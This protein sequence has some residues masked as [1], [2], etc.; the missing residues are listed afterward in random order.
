MLRRGILMGLVLAVTVGAAAGGARAANGADA[1]KAQGRPDYDAAFVGMK[2]PE[3]VTGHEVF[4]VAITMRNTGSKPWGS[5]PLRLRSINPPNNVTWGTNYILVAQGTSVGSGAEYTFRSRLRAPAG[6]GKRGFQWQVCKDGKTWFGETTPAK[7]IEVAPRPPEAATTAAAPRRRS[8]GKDVLRF[9]DFEYVGSFKPPKTVGKTRGAF[10][11]SGVALRR[12]PGGADRLFMNYTHP[13]GALF[14]IEIPELV[15]IEA[16]RP[17]ALKTARV[18]KVWGR[19]RIPKPGEQAIGPNGGFVWDDGQRMLHW[20]WY[21]GYKTGKA[22]PV[23]GATKLPADGEMSYTG[24]WYVSAPSRLYKSYWGGVIELPKAFA[25]K[26]TGGKTLAVGF[27]GY[28]SIC[29]SAS[30]GPALGAIPRPDPRKTTV[31]V[32]EMLYH[33]AASPAPR[34]GDYFSANCGYWHDRPKSPA[35]GSWTFDDFCRAGAFIDAPAG[36]AYVAFVCLGTGRL[37]YDFGSITHAGTSQ[38]WYFYDPKDLGEAARGDRKPTQIAPASMAKVAYPLG[39][40]VTGAC[41]DAK[42]RLLYLC[43]TWA[44]PHGRESYPVVH[45]YRLR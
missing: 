7:T 20:T 30:R 43:V 39:H 45:A 40:S 23:L 17:A 35:R 21:H 37:G 41:Y 13:T 5:W 34:D 10:S 8:E 24:P 31:P 14:E 36:H 12:M 18:A 38:Y 44:Y 16:G 25:E 1:A 28:Y 33:T 6:P 4:S 19:L 11:A 42:S 29:G 27:G 26:Y 32:T 3:K 9:D 2:I 15:K 22:P